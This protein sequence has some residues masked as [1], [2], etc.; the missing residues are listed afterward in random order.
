M[1]FRVEF[2]DVADREFEVD[3]ESERATTTT[4]VRLRHF[5]YLFENH[6]KSNAETHRVGRELNFQMFHPQ[7]IVDQISCKMA[8]EKLCIYFLLQP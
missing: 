8:D 4:N 7:T 6:L 2:D 5:D 1:A 3:N